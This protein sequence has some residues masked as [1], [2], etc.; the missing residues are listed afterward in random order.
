MIVWSKWSEKLKNGIKIL[1]DSA[2]LEL[3]DQKRQINFF[4]Q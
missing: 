3:F 1:V 4:D 2:V